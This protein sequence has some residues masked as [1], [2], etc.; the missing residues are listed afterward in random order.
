MPLNKLIQLY[1]DLRAILVKNKVEEEWIVE[2]FSRGL[3]KGLE[4]LFSIK[5][6]FPVVKKSTSFF[7][8]CESFLVKK[9]QVDEKKIK[10]VEKW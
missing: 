8:L 2:A 9:N 5:C 4:H 7:E 6:D 10:V 1:Q 3:I